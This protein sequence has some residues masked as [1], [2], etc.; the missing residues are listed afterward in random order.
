MLVALEALGTI[1]LVAYA[2]VGFLNRGDADVMQSVSIVLVAAIAAFWVT[3]TAVGL[4][5]KRGWSRGSALT[6]QI[7]IFS[8]AVGA[9]QGI[10]A[11][12]V[13]GWA[14]AAPAVITFAAALLAHD[15]Q[16]G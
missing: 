12:P 6:I 16:K 11:Q 9:L 8:I 4:S 10:F 2:F 3:A 1:A 14:L 5:R 7:F 13:I 15:G